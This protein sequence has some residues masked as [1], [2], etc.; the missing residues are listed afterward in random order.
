[1]ACEVQ[2]GEGEG[3]EMAFARKTPPALQLEQAPQDL[4]GIALV[5]S[6]SALVEM[7]LRVMQLSEPGLYIAQIAVE[8]API[9]KVGGLG[10]VVTALG[11]AVKEQG[12]HMDIILPRHGIL[13]AA[14][15]RM[16]LACSFAC[17]LFQVPA[18]TPA[19]SLYCRHRLT[20]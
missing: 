12:H 11:R 17:S 7:A 20:I 4:P 9:C 3:R 19:L 5:L 6:L 10:D 13:H 8:M 1:M 18:L 2:H 16:S 14:A 15:F